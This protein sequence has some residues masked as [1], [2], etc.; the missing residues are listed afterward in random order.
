MKINQL[1]EKGHRHGYWEE[2][3]PNGSLWFKGTYNNNNFEGYW[4]V[5]YRNGNPWFKGNYDNNG[6]RIGYWE[7]YYDNGE[8]R[9][10]IFHS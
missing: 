3:H 10:Q 7:W 1:N 9:E 6:T 8:L 5:Y 2:Y 4:E